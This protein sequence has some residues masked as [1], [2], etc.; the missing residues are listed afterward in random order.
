[1][2]GALDSLTVTANTSLSEILE[3]F[4]SSTRDLLLIDERTVITEP[5]LELLTDYPRST[6]AALV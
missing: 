5:H 4:Q 2:S 1:M 3:T 6:S